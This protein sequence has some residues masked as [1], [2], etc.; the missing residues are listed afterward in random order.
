MSELLTC[1]CDN[2]LWCGSKY[3]KD[4]VPRQ[5]FTKSNS[6][7]LYKMCQDCR[8]YRTETNKKNK[9]I[10]IEKYN[11]SIQNKNDY[12]PC[13]ALLHNNEIYPKDKVP[14]SQFIKY[15]NNP[16][17]P[18]TKFCLDC[19]TK[20]DKHIKEKRK[21]NCVKAEEKGMHYCSYCNNT[22]NQNECALNI[23]GTQSNCCKSCQDTKN[24]QN[25]M[26]KLNF[27]NLKF[28]YIEKY[29]SCCYLCHII[30]VMHD[31]HLI[32]LKTELIKNTRYLEYNN[33]KYKVDDFIQLYKNKIVHDILQFDHLTE[34]EMRERNLLKDYELYESK[35]RKISQIQNEAL[36]KF[37][38]LKCQLLCGRCHLIKTIEREKG[39]I[40]KNVIRR[41]KQNYTNELKKEGCCL[42]HYVNLDLLRFFHFDHIDPST[43]IDNISSMVSEGKYSFDHLINEIK[44]CRIICLHCH[45]LHTKN[46]WCD[47]VY[48]T[49]IEK[50]EIIDY[51]KPTKQACVKIK[52]YDHFNNLI[53]EYDSIREASRKCN[54]KPYHINDML[55]GKKNHPD[56]IFERVD[57]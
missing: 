10:N 4:K 18:F 26:L 16:N 49:K 35:Y 2:H 50:P 57:V 22:I 42:C 53:E 20:K 15:P 51:I 47:D 24:K 30:F 54:I 6:E 27:V 31:D 28:E 7:E 14:K 40:Y 32:E 1:S 48:R 56:F 37:E 23:D 55:S 38:A 46:Q 5:S 36:M 45:M 33:K 12:M 43:K 44:K 13:L 8:N 29:Q 39:T 9:I 11:Q 19:R 3:P 25:K 41:K 34:I 17:S 52:K 21:E